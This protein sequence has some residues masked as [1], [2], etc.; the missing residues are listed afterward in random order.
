MEDTIYVVDGTVLHLY[1]VGT[2][3]VISGRLDQRLIT[4]VNASLFLKEVSLNSGYAF[5]GGAIATSA[6][7]LILN[8]TSFT[9]NQAGSTGG[10][11]YV[12]DGSSVTLYGDKTMFFNN[13]AAGSGG[14]NYAAGAS[15]ISWMGKKTDFTDNISQLDGGA[16]NIIFEFIASWTGEV[17]FSNNG[18]GRYGGAVFPAAH[19][20][21]AW[22]GAVH[23]SNSTAGE[24][25]NA[26]MI[27]DS[28]ITGKAGMTFYHN[29]AGTA[30]G[31][32][33]VGYFSILSWA[34]VTRFE[35]NRGGAGGGALVV[36]MSS[37][38]SGS[39]DMLF[40]Q[41]RAE[42]AGAVLVG[43]ESTIS[44]G[45]NTNFSSNLAEN[46]GGGALYILESSYAIFSGVSTLAENSAPERLGGA[47]VVYGSSAATW[48][49]KVTFTGNSAGGGGVLHVSI[50]CTVNCEQN[51]TFEGNAAISSSVFRTYKTVY[52]DI[53][54]TS[55]AGAV[56]VGLNSNISWSEETTFSSN[57][58]ETL[59]GGLMLLTTSNALWGEKATFINNSAP[60]GLGGAIAAFE[61]SNVSWMYDVTFMNNSAGSG[62][63][64]FVAR[65]CTVSYRGDA[66]FEDN[67]ASSKDGGDFIALYTSHSS[68]SN[69]RGRTAFWLGGAVYVGWN[70]NIPWSGLTTFSYN[71]AEDG[72]GAPAL[73]KNSNALWT[74]KTTFSLTIP[75]DS[76]VGGA[77]FA[78][79]SSS[80][81]WKSDANFTRNIART[82]G[83]LYVDINCIISY[84]GITTFDGN[85]ASGRQGGALSVSSSD[86]YWKN[87]TTF[88]DNK[89]ELFGGAVSF[90]AEISSSDRGSSL[91]LA[92]PT[93]L[94]NNTC[95][96][97]GGAVGLIGD[98]VVTLETT[99]ITFSGNREAVAGGAIYIWGND[100]G[101]EFIGVKFLFNRAQHGGGVH[102]T[103]S[104]NALLVST[105][106]NEAILSPSR[107]AFFTITTRLRRAAQSKARPVRT[108]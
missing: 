37:Y 22:E 77:L 106:S 86:V 72:G 39:G 74:G 99:D 48:G 1:G 44:W 59:G 70:S 5:V 101:P 104:G 6:S 28:N 41:N 76:G 108:L 98:V 62:G 18:C 63:A 56:F 23:L 9:G 50:N 61:S 54:A 92:G 83:A 13:V 100:L 75:P 91:I 40:S 89:A 12:V 79:K 103:G 52:A 2:D 57:T 27:I 58:A 88:V 73:D 34:G 32:L 42:K 71:T 45:G 67:V 55:Y 29:S 21:V 14:A 30:A 11:L 25:C 78:V 53:K 69:S 17:L 7:R 10:A 43:Y 105:A 95:E 96:T 36:V 66:Y 93:I 90:M 38:A 20:S 19:A 15:V 24:W 102:S 82:R 3:A 35:G 68:T 81:S 60:D 85:S 47:V 4:V 97:N 16:I 65:D 8:H 64:L 49:S 80:A 107:G 87:K 33:Y 51:T 84:S 94:L 26:A 31:G 46:G